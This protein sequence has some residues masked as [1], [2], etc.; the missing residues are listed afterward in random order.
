[1]DPSLYSDEAVA[2]RRAAAEAAA[3]A[4]ADLKAARIAA[5]TKAAPHLLAGAGWVLLTVLAQHIT[6]PNWKADSGLKDSCVKALVKLLN[7]PESYR[8]DVGPGPSFY[9]ESPAQIQ[10]HWQYRAKNGYGGY[11]KPGNAYC[12][13]EKK[14]RSI[15]I[16]D[17]P[18]VLET[19][20]YVDSVTP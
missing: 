20:G 3:K 7:D 2:A 9:T 1:V 19:T 6:S 14:N 18:E 13:A 10:F 17:S 4:A 5:I 8:Q 16:M 11:G 15:K 12:I